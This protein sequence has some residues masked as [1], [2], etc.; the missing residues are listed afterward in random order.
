MGRVTS[1]KDKEVAD[2]Q[3]VAGDISRQSCASIV[4]SD[5]DRESHSLTLLRAADASH[6]LRFSR[7]SR[8]TG[9]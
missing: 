4:V 2:Y 6:F 8:N 3:S 7:A 9:P 1:D 5:Y